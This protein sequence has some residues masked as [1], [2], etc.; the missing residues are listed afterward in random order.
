[1]IDRHAAVLVGLFA[2]ATSSCGGSDRERASK[3]LDTPVLDDIGSNAVLCNA[4]EDYELQMLQ[5]FEL[6]S[7]TGGWYYNN[8]QCDKCQKVIDRIKELSSQ[9][10]PTYLEKAPTSIYPDKW[11]CNDWRLTKLV[12]E[13][14]AQYAER[15]E[16][17]D[18]SGFAPRSED[19]TAAEYAKRLMDAILESYNTEFLRLQKLMID[20]DPANNVPA[21]C[22]AVCEASQ[23]PS[24]YIKPLSA[25]RIEFMDPE[26][27]KVVAQ[28]RCGSQFAMHVKGGPFQTWGGTFAVQFGQPGLDGGGWDGISFWA[29]VGPASRHPLRIEIADGRN[30]DKQMLYSF[31]GDTLPSHV[32]QAD[33]DAKDDELVASGLPPLGYFDGPTYAKSWCKNQQFACNADSIRED[34]NGCDK[35]GANRTMTGDWQ[36]YSVDFLNVRQSGWGMPVMDD[37]GNAAPLDSTDMRTLVFMWTTGTWDVWIDDVAFYRRKQ[38]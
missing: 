18:A 26:T 35:F 5:D 3:P 1:V 38:P 34:R 8:D 7:V 24:A 17:P 11:G 4:T 22:R 37:Q 29:R 9:E 25:S 31:P 28:P 19:E 12:G 15:V 21:N 30:D 27:G 14:D 6:G 36:F 2:V 33:L 23:T 16:P 13:T 10:T 32:T 20:G